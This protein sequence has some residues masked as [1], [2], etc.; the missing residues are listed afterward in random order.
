[1]VKLQLAK[2][3]L[4][5]DYLKLKKIKNNIT[6]LNV[7]RYLKCKNKQFKDKFFKKNRIK[8]NKKMK[9]DNLAK[10]LIKTLFEEI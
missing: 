7:I 3:L 9:K 4:I 8:L 1:M 10:N 2:R 6:K 5:G